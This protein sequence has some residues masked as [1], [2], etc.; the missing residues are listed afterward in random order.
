MRGTQTSVKNDYPQHLDVQHRNSVKRPKV[1][2]N[3]DAHAAIMNNP[4]VEQTAMKSQPEF[5][6]QSSCSDL[7]NTASPMKD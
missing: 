3:V 6:N 4:D 2:I 5:L 1:E 7:V